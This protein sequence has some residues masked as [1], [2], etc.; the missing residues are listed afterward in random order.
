MLMTEQRF[1]S[2][3]QD[4]LADETKRS[5][6]I[7]WRVNSVMVARPIIYPHIGQ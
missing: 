4:V 7:T 1:A 2:Y 3:C 6:V 5:E